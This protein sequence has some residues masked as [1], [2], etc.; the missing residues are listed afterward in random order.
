MIAYLTARVS[1]RIK[2]EALHGA[3]WWE[4]G[5]DYMNSALSEAGGFS[6]ALQRGALPA[7]DNDALCKSRST[8]RRAASML[9]QALL[10]SD[11]TF[12]QSLRRYRRVACTE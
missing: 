3:A 5:S 2:R 10:N 9:P 4:L 1:R 12:G 11:E 8:L 7:F 6:G